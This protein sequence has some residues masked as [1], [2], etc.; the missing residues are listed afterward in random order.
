MARLVVVSTTERANMQCRAVKHRWALFLTLLQVH[1][2]ANIFEKTT[3]FGRRADKTAR[4]L[5]EAYEIGKEG[6]MC[7]SQTC[8]FT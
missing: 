5:L 8:L 1:V 4:E 3:I 2:S 6:E 7:A